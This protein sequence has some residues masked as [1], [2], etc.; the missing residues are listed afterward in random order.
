MDDILEQKSKR[1][2]FLNS[3]KPT[4]VSSLIIAILSALI[5]YYIHSKAIFL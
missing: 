5:K 1:F 4:H 2:G 3:Y